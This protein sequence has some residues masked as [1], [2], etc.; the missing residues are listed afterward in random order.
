MFFF[1]ISLYSTIQ[2]LVNSFIFSSGKI[3]GKERRALNSHPHVH[4]D[5]VHKE[6]KENTKALV[7]HQLHRETAWSRRW[8]VLLCESVLSSQPVVH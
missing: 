5:M 3:Q 6:P 8:V 7:T 4:K 1:I 2:S